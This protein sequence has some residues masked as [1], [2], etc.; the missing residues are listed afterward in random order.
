[1]KCPSY[2]ALHHSDLVIAFIHAVLL[3]A[4]HLRDMH[5]IVLLQLDTHLTIFPLV[6]DTK[7]TLKAFFWHS[8]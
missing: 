4:L 2:L 5:V 8:A 3:I 7:S 1:M 6:A